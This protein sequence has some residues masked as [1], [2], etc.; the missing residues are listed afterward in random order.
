MYQLPLSFC[1]VGQQVAVCA[2]RIVALMSTNAFQARQTI[3]NEKR[4]GTLI[5]AAGRAAVKT[6]IFLDNGTVIASP[7]TVQ[8][9][10]T[11]IEKSNSKQVNTRRGVYQTARLKVYEA[12]D[13]EPDTINDV[14]VPSI[15]IDTSALRQEE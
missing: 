7:L 1:S 5:N 9:I 13:E 4:A 3:K 10:L 14:E 6:A 8:R 11:A 15:T 2:T 12:V